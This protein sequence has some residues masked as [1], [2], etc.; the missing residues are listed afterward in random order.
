[1]IVIFE[2]KSSDNF[3][4]C[5]CLLPVVFGF[6]FVLFLYIVLLC[7]APCVSGASLVDYLVDPAYCLP[8]ALLPLNYERSIQIEVFCLSEVDN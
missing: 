5:I 6:E 8:E 3:S 1:L 2:V 7:S 4:S